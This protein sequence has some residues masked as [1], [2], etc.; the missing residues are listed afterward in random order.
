VTRESRQLAT[1]AQ[2]YAED[3][4]RLLNHTVC[5]GAYVGAIV[6]PDG[7]TA[8]VGT[9]VRGVGGESSDTTANSRRPALLADRCRT[10]L[11]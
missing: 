1:L 7:K 6:R 3:L 11:S 4:T 2:K 8:A 5:D 9:E 10:G